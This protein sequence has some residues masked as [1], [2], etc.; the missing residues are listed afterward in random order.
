MQDHHILRKTILVSIMFTFFFPLLAFAETWTIDPDH[1]AGHFSI[2]HLMISQVRGMFAGVQGAIVFDGKQPKSI[3]VRIDV[4]RVDTGVV[5]RDEHLKTADFF[6]AATHPQMTFVSK[7]IEPATG[8][9]AA[10]GT[11]T[12]RGV[13][14]EVT[15]PVR[16]LN[17][18]VVDPWK[19][20]RRGAT[21]HFTI[22]R[23]DYKVAW[24]APLGKDGVAVGNDV[25][26]IVDLE[27][28]KPE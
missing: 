15:I 20:T 16:G 28:L 11:L 14:R 4:N 8:G 3:Y 26:I 27:V 6:D 9:Y 24:N 23:Q 5:K 22:N 18:D 19:Q 10:T 1:S 2:Q 25:D 12:I 21:A 13:S 17:R 7:R